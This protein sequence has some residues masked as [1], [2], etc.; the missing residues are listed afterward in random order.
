MYKLPE[1]NLY[2]KQIEEIIKKGYP[3]IVFGSGLLG[4]A[5]VDLLL[6]KNA[7]V[8]EI[9]DNN[10]QISGTAYR[11]ITITVPHDI[12]D[13]N[14]S[15]VVS[16]YHYM[17]SISNQ[18]AELGY[19]KIFPY[20]CCFDGQEVSEDFYWNNDASIQDAEFFE[21]RDMLLDKEDFLALNVVEIAITEKCSL[22]CKHCANLIQYYEKPRHEDTEKNIKAFNR[23][24]KCVDL[25][26][27]VNIL[28][29]EP[30]LNKE[31]PLYV[32]ACEET[33]KITK[34]IIVTNGTVPVKPEL[35]NEM[36]KDGRCVMSISNYG[37]LSRRKE[38]IIELLDKEGI[39]VAVSRRDG[40]WT[41]RGRIE[42]KDLSI[43]ELIEKYKICTMKKFISIKDGKLFVCPFAANA[44]SLEAISKRDF[45]YIDLLDDNIS[46]D[47]LREA[48][49]TFLNRNSHPECKYCI[50]M[51][52]KGRIV[53][54]AVQLEE[55]MTYKRCVD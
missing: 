22:K 41:E 51:G 23:L 6:D 43:D 10:K 19:T 7:N 31:L 42:Y 45:A 4:K 53:P 47:E 29:G 35:I 16:V 15:V 12:T 40:V 17:V 54:A 32:R 1:I 9:F 21:R 26:G 33:D 11:G 27:K 28:G 34:I 55:V 25:I 50:E 39:N 49:R 38:E 48:I 52:D 2:K 36:K 13:K 46:D 30:L 3:V 14:T 20:Y 8:V 5:V 24:I 37:D 18:L 44:Y